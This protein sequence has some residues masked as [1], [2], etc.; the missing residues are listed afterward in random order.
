MDFSEIATNLRLREDGVWTSC[1]T[2]SV[3]YPEDGNESCLQLE[4]QS[5]WFRH[6]NNIIS[7]AVRHFAPNTKLFDIGGGNGC[8]SARLESE[9]IQTVLVEPGSTGIK[10]AKRR[11][12]TTLIQS[13][14]WDAGF[15]PGTIPTAGAFDVLEHIA[16]DKKF[17]RL[18]HD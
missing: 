17:V 3:S 8:V 12:L 6:R 15:K 2:E 9:R 16:D 11:D 1:S 10:N 18:V 5:F 4:D 14:L 7:S 13:T